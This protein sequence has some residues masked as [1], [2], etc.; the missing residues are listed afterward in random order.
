[1]LAYENSWISADQIPER[2]VDQGLIDRLGSLD[3]QVGGESSRYSL[4]TQWQNKGW[5]MNAY[6][7]RSDLDLFSNFTYFLDD[8]ING[9]Q[10]EQVD[11]RMIYGGSVEHRQ[12][13]H[14]GDRHLSQHY[15]VQVRYDDI[16]DV[17][18]YR[19]ANS[20]FPRSDSFSRGGH[21]ITKPDR[22]GVAN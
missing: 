5:T 17:A 21:R 7:I 12:T 14:L 15:G 6:A 1:M 19:P 2:A 22:D 18:L 13:S 8:P 10:F 3:D 9:D 16:L 20:L 4:S 11:S